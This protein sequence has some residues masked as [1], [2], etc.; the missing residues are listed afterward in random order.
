MIRELLTATEMR[1]AEAAAISAGKVTGLALMERAGEGLVAAIAAEWP[2]ALS[3]DATG[4]VVVLCGPGNNG[5]DGFVIA[6][7]LANA[8]RA[9]TVHLHG[10]LDRLPPDA[11]TNADRW[12][13]L[14]G[15]ITPLAPDTA[16][17]SGADLII[18]ALFGTGLTR[19]LP[20]DLS[21]LATATAQAREAGAR[22]VAVDLPSGLCADSGRPIGTAFTADLT[23]TFHAEKLGHRLADGPDHCGHLRLVDIGLAPRPAG[24]TLADLSADDA[25][26]IAKTRGHKFGH[27]HAF[28]L[29]GGIG[30]GGATRLAARAALRVG[31]G[32]VTLGVPPAAEAENAAQLNAIMLT[33][34][35]T[36]LSLEQV[37]ADTRINALCAGPGMA[38]GSAEAELLKV[39]LTTRRPVVFDAGAITIMAEHEELRDLAH[40]ACVLTPHDGEFARIFPAL[41]DQLATPTDRGPA[42]SRVDAARA[43]AR[44]SGCIIV[45]KGPDTVIA[46]PDGRCSIHSAAYGREA[47]WLATAGS[48]DVLAGLI[49]GL[50]ARGFAP[51]EAARTAAWLHVES[52]RAFGPGLIAEDLPEI[53]PQVFRALAL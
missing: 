32:L 23:V 15:T 5:G 11:R 36:S 13:A 24:V 47:P 7:L 49:T 22:V 50:M 20:P 4:P 46:D 26:R 31:A 33:R 38:Q 42:F 48:G 21:T 53:L 29:S 37:L 40:P 8:G 12:L 9:V 35:F 28:V 30:H 43:A 1:E 45:L 19:P 25:R 10:A 2:D 6:R 52:A 34:V 16:P 18:D 27:G 3:P 41:A 14:G 51:F 17:L 44:R 39:M